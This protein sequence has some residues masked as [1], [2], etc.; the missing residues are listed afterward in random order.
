MK[1][2]EDRGA[3]YG[4][5]NTFPRAGD[6]MGWETEVIPHGSCLRF[7]F[8]GGFSLVAKSFGSNMTSKLFFLRYFI[9]S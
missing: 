9:C 7:G 5:F 6:F 1:C 8:H 2:Y 4:C 3:K